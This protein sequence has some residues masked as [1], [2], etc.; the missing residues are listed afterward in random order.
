[1]VYEKEPKPGYCDTGLRFSSDYNS[2]NSPSQ[3]ISS[4][5]TTSEIVKKYQLGVFY[6]G[7][8]NRFL[9]LIP[10]IILFL[11]I[12]ITGGHEVGAIDYCIGCRI[13]KVI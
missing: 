4:A 11:H 6:A 1:M 3:V 7:K 9:T 13:R 5:T 10:V 12:V 2:D 8:L